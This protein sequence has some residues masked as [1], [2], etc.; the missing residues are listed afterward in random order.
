[1][2]AMRDELAAGGSFADVVAA[3][4][5]RLALDALVPW[6]RWITPEAESRRFDARF[7]L[8]ELPA[9]QV[10]QHDQHETT[11]SF[12]D[13]PARILER[14]A[15]GEFFLAPPTART[16]EL[17]AGAGDVATAMAIARRQ[18][19]APICPRFVAADGGGA[20]YLALPGDPSHEV[21]ERRVDGPTRYVLRDGRFVAEDPT[22][23]CA[24][25]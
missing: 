21:T 10:G 23:S 7:Y 25:A 1:V 13:A 4:G 17:L 16:L 12:W 24:G 15:R 18:S 22:E 6:A 9:G 11:E 3:R 19:L 2:E 14:A 8:L 5:L 20:P